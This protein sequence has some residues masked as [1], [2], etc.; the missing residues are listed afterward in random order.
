MNCTKEVPVCCVIPEAIN[1]QISYTN[2]A[3]ADLLDPATPNGI[4]KD[5]VDIYYLQNGVKTQVYYP[6]LDYPKNFRISQTG[7]GN[8]YF[9]LLWAST[10]EDRNSITTTY[11]N[12]RNRFEDTVTAEVTRYGGRRSLKKVWINGVQLNQIDTVTLIR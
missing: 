9:L 7:M 4:R 10:H 12:V 8:K 3:K 11:I 6:N 5:D 1:L 2:S